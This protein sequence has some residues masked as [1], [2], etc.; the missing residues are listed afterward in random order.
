MIPLEHIRR[1]NAVDHYR[2]NLHNF[3]IATEYLRHTRM[4]NL[5]NCSTLQR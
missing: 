5:T 1:E 4:N 3:D 2:H